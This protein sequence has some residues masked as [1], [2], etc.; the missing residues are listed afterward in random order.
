ML[1]YSDVC[2]RDVYNLTS[3]YDVTDSLSSKLTSE[4]SSESLV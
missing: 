3:V 2:L 1:D 4:C